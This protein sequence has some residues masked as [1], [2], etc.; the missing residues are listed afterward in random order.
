MPAKKL[1]FEWHSKA[2]VDRFP[3]WSMG[4]IVKMRV[5][6]HTKANQSV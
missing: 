6:L 4:T 5:I 1:D 3:R 2:E